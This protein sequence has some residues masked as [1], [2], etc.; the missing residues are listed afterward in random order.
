MAKTEIM[1]AG[2]GGQGILSMGKL[3]AQAAMMEGKNVS[4]LPSYGPEMRGGTAN[5][6]VVI[7]DEPV[8]AP[9]VAKADVLIV[10]NTPSL[11]KF[12]DMVKEN[13]VIIVDSSLVQEEVTR[14]DVRV[15]RLPATKMAREEK[16]AAFAGIY[17]L[18]KTIGATGVI[19]AKFFEEAL[20]ETLPEKHQKLIPKEM[21]VLQVGIDF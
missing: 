1:I 3:I 6:Q 17:L 2:F 11:V 13:G 8:G 7:S 5:C 15:Y 12:E 9:I 19:D 16:V 10:M 20:K 21:E 18:G 4:W 14:K